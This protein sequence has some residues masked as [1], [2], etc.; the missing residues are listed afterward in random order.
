M[1]K[2]M[3]TTIVEANCPNVVD[4]ND[5]VPLVWH[6]GVD[7][8]PVTIGITVLTRQMYCSL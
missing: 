3:M 5:T 1:L 2:L 4:E 7:I 8:G 6:L